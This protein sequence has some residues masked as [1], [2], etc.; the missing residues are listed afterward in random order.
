MT[1]E[2]LQ[3]INQR[4]KCEQSMRINWRKYWKNKV[5]P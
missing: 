3:R 2:Q 1:E 4:K 5:I